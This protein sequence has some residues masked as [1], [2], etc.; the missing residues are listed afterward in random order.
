[1][2]LTVRKT[3]SGALEETGAVVDVVAGLGSL[4]ATDFDA[5]V[6]GLYVASLPPGI[7]PILQSFADDPDGS[8][9]VERL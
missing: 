8:W 1:M 4:V 3:Q 9:T 2:S 5:D 7:S 6:S